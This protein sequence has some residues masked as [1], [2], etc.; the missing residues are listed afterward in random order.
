M[1]IEIVE[2]GIVGVA[3]IDDAGGGAREILR[4]GFAAD[5]RHGLLGE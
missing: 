5:E 4:G 2:G 1:V 3:D